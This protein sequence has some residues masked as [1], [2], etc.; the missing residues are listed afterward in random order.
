MTDA[1]IIILILALGVVSQL[2]HKKV[3]SK[4]SELE[5][6]LTAVNATLEKARTEI[7]DAVAKLQEQID[8]QADPVLTE[9]AQAQLDRLTA[10]AATLDG[11][12]PDAPAQPAV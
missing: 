2:N 5:S 8:N 10:L 12:N 3:M 9:A 1:L 11:L 4:L 6:T 7:V